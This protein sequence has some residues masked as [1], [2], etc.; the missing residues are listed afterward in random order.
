MQIEKIKCRIRNRLFV[1]TPEERVRQA[2]LDYLIDER[3]YPTGYFSVENTI[4]VNG[5]DRRTDI[6]IHTPTGDPLMI[7]E[8]KA[9][10]VKLDQA[11]ISQIAMYN[12]VLDAPYLLLSNGIENHM[13]AL[14]IDEK[15]MEQLRIVPFYKDL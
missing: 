9:P 7:V 11:I 13:F 8:C 2:I 15:K 3:G 4:R 6:L 14:N 10:S 12:S 5:K 1:L